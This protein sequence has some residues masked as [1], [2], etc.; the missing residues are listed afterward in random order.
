MFDVFPIHTKMRTTTPITKIGNDGQLST[1]SP[2]L[3]NKRMLGM[4]GMVARTWRAG[5]LVWVESSLGTGR[6]V[7]RHGRNGRL[8]LADWSLG[9]GGM[10]LGMRRLVARNVRNGVSVWAG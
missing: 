7:A 5:R 9:M 6:I 10:L 1:A 3:A 2:R 4:G 8:D